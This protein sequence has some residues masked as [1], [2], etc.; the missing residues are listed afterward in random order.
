MTKATYKRDLIVFAFNSFLALSGLGIVLYLYFNHPVA[1]GYFI[2]EDH[3]AEYGSFA[4][5]AISF[6]LIAWALWSR[7]GLRK[8]GIFLL[9]FASLLF[10]LEEISWG[11]RIIGFS[12]PDFF[13]VHNRQAEANLHNVAFLKRK[14]L[15]VLIILWCVLPLLL[16]SVVTRLR[17]WSDKLLI[18]IVPIRFWPFFFLAS[19]LLIY[20]PFYYGDEIA[21]LYVGIGFAG[22]SL[23][24]AISNQRRFDENLH[25]M[26]SMLRIILVIILVS[27]VLTHF[28]AKKTPED[29]LNVLASFG[30]PSHGMYRQ[31][32]MVFDFINR[33]PEFSRK[34]TPFNEAVVLKKMGYKEE[35]RE[36]LESM[37]I[38]QVRR[39]QKGPYDPE[40]YRDMGIILTQLERYD[41]AY[42]QFEIALELDRQRLKKVYDRTAEAKIRWSL[43]KTLFAMGDTNAADKQLSNAIDIAPDTFTKSKMR[44]WIKF[45]RV[46]ARFQK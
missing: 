6:C 14:F 40:T 35:A 21:E 34:S 45:E 22:L 37:L 26:Y 16:K 27:M 23:D 17:Q 31:A 43:A 18:P 12:P 30:Y 1:Y 3:W 41:D 11:Q 9:A 46:R 33:N 8:P 36:V 32:K 5:W 44:R 25:Y 19:G 29:K 4:S 2:S 24:I 38:K 42:R 15:A 13:L 20:R 39:R 10:A 28:F 7:P